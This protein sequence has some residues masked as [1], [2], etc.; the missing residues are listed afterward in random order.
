MVRGASKQAS[1]IRSEGGFIVPSGQDQSRDL[2]SPKTLRFGEIECHWIKDPLDQ[3][4]DPKVLTQSDVQLNRDSRILFG[5]AGSRLCSV[6]EAQRSDGGSIKDHE[7]RQ[8][9]VD[10]PYLKRIIRAC[11]GKKQETLR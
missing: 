5:T 8:R 3:R 4:L 7:E 9:E 11:L 6:C 10:D 1:A 2:D